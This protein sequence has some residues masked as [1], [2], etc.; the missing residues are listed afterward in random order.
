[1]T[2]TISL[3]KAIAVEDPQARSNAMSPTSRNRY[4]DEY[5]GV[6]VEHS[7]RLVFPGGESISFYAD[8]KEEKAKW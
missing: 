2:A 7:F 6:N 4:Y 3:K 1:M 5:D 8:T